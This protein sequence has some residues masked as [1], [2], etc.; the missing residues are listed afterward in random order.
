MVDAEGRRTER[1][2]RQNTEDFDAEELEA[3]KEENQAEEELFDQVATCLGSFLK[4][5]SDSV[6]PYLESIW[7]HIAKLLESNRSSE[8]RRI[9]V[10]VVDDLLDYSPAGR[11]RLA[12]QVRRCRR[13][14]RPSNAMAWMKVYL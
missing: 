5:F 4:K 7:P 1:L 9:A 11:A 6:L 2:K 12:P 13:I 3:L 8:E 14:Y 10:C